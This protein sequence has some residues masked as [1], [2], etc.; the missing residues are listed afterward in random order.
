MIEAENKEECEKGENGYESLGISYHPQECLGNVDIS[1]KDC[2]VCS[3][4]TLSGFLKILM[5]LW[6]DF[7]PLTNLPVLVELVE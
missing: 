7:L 1:L 5:N 6:P 4:L 2:S 3:Y